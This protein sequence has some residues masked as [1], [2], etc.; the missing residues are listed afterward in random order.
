MTRKASSRSGCLFT[1]IPRNS[2]WYGSDFN[3][4][5]FESVSLFQ[6]LDSDNEVVI[7]DGGA[8]WV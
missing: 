1:A 7:G 2:M 5:F 8:A 3:A 6:Y 4:N